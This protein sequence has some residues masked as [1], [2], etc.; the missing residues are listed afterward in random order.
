MKIQYALISLSLYLVGNLKKKMEDTELQSMFELM[1]NIESEEK[2]MKTSSFATVAD[3][4][5]VFQPEIKL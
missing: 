2:V 3:K 5:E 4:K 1:D